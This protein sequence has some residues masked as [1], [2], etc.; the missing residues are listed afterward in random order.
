[1]EAQLLQRAKIT[2]SNQAKSAASNQLQ[3][4]GH[5]AWIRSSSA[6]NRRRSNHGGSRGTRGE[7]EAPS[8][9][10]SCGEGA[11]R[12]GRGTAGMDSRG[13]GA[14]RGGRGAGGMG[15]TRGGSRGGAALAWVPHEEGAAPPSGGAR[16]VRRL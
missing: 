15:L 10:G 7:A 9:W 2:V 12:G 5:S 13:K 3:G 4:R 1:M 16:E 6:S 14:A 11:A 8:A